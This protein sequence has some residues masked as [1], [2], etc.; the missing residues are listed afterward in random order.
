MRRDHGGGTGPLSPFWKAA[1]ELDPDAP[2]E[3]SRPGSSRGELA[4]LLADAGLGEVEESALTVE[5]VHPDFDEWWVPYT[6]GVG[7]VGV[8]VAGLDEP[9]R[10]RLRERLRQRFP[11]DGVV[12]VRAWVARG[13]A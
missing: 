4:E 5:V 13:R 12:R 11:A 2:G 7:P 9:R 6:E 10:E 8:Y 3:S 1:H